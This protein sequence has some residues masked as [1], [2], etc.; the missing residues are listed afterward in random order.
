MTEAKYFKTETFGAV[1]GPGTRLIIF[2]QGC[3][4]RCIYCHN[5]ESWEVDKGTKKIS[6]NE[7]IKLYKDNEN[8]YKNGGGITISGGEPCLHI[9]FLIALGKRC[10]KEGIHLTIDTSGYFFKE[11]YIKKTNELI[12]Y[13]DLFLVDI[14]Q[15]NNKKYKTITRVD[16]SKQS[17][18]DFVKY[19]EENSKHYWIRQ[20]L[21]PGYTDDKD[22][23][24]KLGEFMKDLKFMDKFELLP[25]HNMAVF[26]YKDLKIKYILK[27]LEPPT[28]EEIR[29]AMNYI[30]E[31]MG[32]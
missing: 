26:K 6:I 31:G 20:V 22:D 25:Y 8:F 23:L 11:A 12:K 13:V 2:L 1:D 21:V 19:L 29:K 24:I 15:I 9:D 5:P 10:K 28:I 27:N 16:A 17:E 18:V 4:L 32:K 14:K 3:P 30:K 7:I